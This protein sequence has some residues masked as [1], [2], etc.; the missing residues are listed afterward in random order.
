MI[1]IFSSIRTD[2]PN[3]GYINTGERGTKTNFYKGRLPTFYLLQ[4][5]KLGVE[6]F[7]H[8]CMSSKVSKLLASPNSVWNL[9]HE[10]L[11]SILLFIPLF[12][13]GSRATASVHAIL[14]MQLRIKMVLFTSIR[15][16]PLSWGEV[17]IGEPHFS[18]QSGSLSTCTVW[19]RPTMLAE[20]KR[21]LHVLCTHK[22][23]HRDK[24][25]CQQKRIISRLSWT[26]NNQ[27]SPDSVFQS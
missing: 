10:R 25:T 16:A 6:L 11:I 22:N 4:V 7:R 9:Q 20:R 18:P 19:L 27:L 12:E 1:M 15:L 5:P 26:P 2:I 24:I 3:L 17:P 13:I 23:L 21:A 14:R 8:Q